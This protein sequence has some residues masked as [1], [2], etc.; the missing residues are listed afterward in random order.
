MVKVSKSNYDLFRELVPEAEEI[1]RV[2]PEAIKSWM[3]D[4]K[5]DHDLG[6]RITLE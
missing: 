6:R 1:P 2:I 4:P 5:P 3:Q